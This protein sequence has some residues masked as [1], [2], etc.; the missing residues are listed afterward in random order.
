MNNF[1]KTVHFK[2]PFKLSVKD[3]AGHNLICILIFFA[4]NKTA[5]SR[6]KLLLICALR[7]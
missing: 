1:L 3:E 6:N 4:P 7:F 2:K 5:L